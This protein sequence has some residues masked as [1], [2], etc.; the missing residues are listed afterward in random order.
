MQVASRHN[1]RLSIGALLAAALLVLSLPVTTDARK[2]KFRGLV[3]ESVSKKGGSS[4]RPPTTFRANVELS[5][6]NRRRARPQP[7]SVSLGGVTGSNTFT[8]PIRR[9]RS[10][11]V[12]VAITV[13]GGTP[14]GKY[15]LTACLGGKV[16]RGTGRCRTRK[17]NV[18]VLS[19]RV[20]LAIS[21]T[22]KAFGDVPVN[23]DSPQQAFTI[24]NNSIVTSTTPSTTISGVGYQVASNG[25]TAPIAPG[26]VCSVAVLFHPTSTGSQNGTLKVSAS[27]DTA[28]ASLS[29]TGV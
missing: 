4:V 22:S 1:T 12:R 25:C 8:P 21:P 3:L 11:T 17:K 26:G 10:A 20:H 2:R 19:T 18:N 24:T 9:H 28:S 7:L 15:P 27:G 29:G 14:V 23:T 13:P 6:P 5:N 16:F